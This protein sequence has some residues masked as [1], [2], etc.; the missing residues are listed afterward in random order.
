MFNLFNQAALRSSAAGLPAVTM[1]N[2]EYIR[3]KILMGA[4]RKAAVIS[5]STMK[6]TA[7]HEAGHALVALL[8][9]G[10]NPVHK[11][12]IMPRGNAL[13]LVASLPDGDN[14]S[15][16]RKQMMAQLDVCLAGRIAEELIFGAD[17]VTSGASN[18]IQVATKLARR[19]ITQ[20]GLNDKLGTV[21]IDYKEKTYSSA[22]S[23]MID[24]EIKQLISA[25][26]ERVTKLLTAHKKELEAIALNL[27]E[28][29]TLSGAELVDVIKGNGVNPKQRNQKASREFKDIDMYRGRSANSAAA[30]G[31]SSAPPATGPNGDASTPKPGN[32]PSKPNNAGTVNPNPAP[33]NMTSL[34][35][36][37][38]ASSSRTTQSDT[39]ATT[40][41][42]ATVSKTANSASVSASSDSEPATQKQRGPPKM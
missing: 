38:M 4:E 11:A 7:F 1:E 5:Q 2:L 16:T 40:N 18:D 39:Q 24:E 42:A 13:G 28:Y 20:Y 22:T 6:L 3:D 21:W 10:A 26:Y 17:N 36:K 37:S 19:M 34:F 41:P 33:S 30:L 8:T 32:A 31:K 29:E 12:T 35:G 15:I 23:T 14:T 9:D 27:I 25:S